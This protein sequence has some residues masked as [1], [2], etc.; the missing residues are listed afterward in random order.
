MSMLIL[1]IPQVASSVRVTPAGR[2]PTAKVRA[3]L[4]SSHYIVTASEAWWR[5]DNTFAFH[6]YGLGSIPTLG[7]MWDVFHPSQPMPSGFPLRRAQNC[8]V[9]NRLIRPTDLARTCSG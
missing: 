2:D 4:I 1:L 9:W 5:R 7:C 8:S 3:S 6:S